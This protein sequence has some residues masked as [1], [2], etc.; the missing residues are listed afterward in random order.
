M[1]WV[2]H[3][4]SN[5][6]FSESEILLMGETMAHE[7]GHYIGL[8]HP[9]EDGWVYFDALEDTVTCNSWEQ[10]DNRL[11]DNLM[12]PYPVCTGFSFDSCGRQD[13]LTAEQAGV[14]NRY[15]GVESP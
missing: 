2:A 11:G 8:F 9:V 13:V 10:C 5:G 12:Y 4:G 6:T 15:L 1:S 7:M 3:A 14:Q